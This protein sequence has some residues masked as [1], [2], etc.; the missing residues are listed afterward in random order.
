[1][2][3]S[4]SNWGPSAAEVDL[5]ARND[6]LAAMLCRACAQLD[7]FKFDFDFDAGLSSWWAAHKAFDSQRKGI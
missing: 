3:C 7:A 6:A 5:Q 1:M 4:D 2:P